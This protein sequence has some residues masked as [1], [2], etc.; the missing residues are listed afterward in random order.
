MLTGLSTTVGFRDILEIARGNRPDFFNLRYVKPPPFVSRYLRRE[1]PGWISFKG[2]EL[3]PLDLSPLPAILVKQRAKLS[4]FW[5][6]PLRV[7]GL[8]SLI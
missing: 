6:A 2:D 3:D 1:V 5:S 8:R 7:D 4:I